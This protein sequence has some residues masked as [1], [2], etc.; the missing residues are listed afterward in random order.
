M[1]PQKELIFPKLCNREALVNRWQ[2]VK[3]V[4]EGSITLGRDI[5]I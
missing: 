3:V 4:R 5:V 1:L 2:V